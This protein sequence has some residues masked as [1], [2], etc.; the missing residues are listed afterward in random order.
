MGNMGMV[1]GGAI[2]GICW[3]Y[4][5]SLPFIS[6][7]VGPFV[8]RERFYQGRNVLAVNSVHND[9]LDVGQ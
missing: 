4:Y 1:C 5:L 6:G 9:D 2:C 3:G 8:W 7:G